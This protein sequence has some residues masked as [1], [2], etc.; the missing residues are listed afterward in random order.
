MIIMATQ[1]GAKLEYAPP[2]ARNMPVPVHGLLKIDNANPTVH[3]EWRVSRGALIR[4]SLRC[5]LAALQR[6]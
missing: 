2:R 3:I 1:D 4:I 6:T 5:L